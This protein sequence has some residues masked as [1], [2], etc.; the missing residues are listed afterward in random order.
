MN[1]VSRDV[2]AGQSVHWHHQVHERNSRELLLTGSEVTTDTLRQVSAP[3]TKLMERKTS[4]RK[5]TFLNTFEFVGF[6]S[7]KSSRSR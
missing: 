2:A 7:K 1:S 3:S 6:F 4:E 5:E